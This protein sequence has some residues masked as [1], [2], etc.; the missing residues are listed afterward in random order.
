LTYAVNATAMLKYQYQG[1]KELKKYIKK[2]NNIMKIKIA[3]TQNKIR[4]NN[5]P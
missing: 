5:N 2:Y 3:Q 1:A 4:R